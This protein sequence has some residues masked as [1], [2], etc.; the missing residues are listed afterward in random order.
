[1]S[2]R[3]VLSNE[4]ID[5]IS[6]QFVSY[7]ADNKVPQR[8]AMEL[9]L[10]LEEVLLEFQGEFGKDANV[11]VE[12]RTLFGKRVLKVQLMGHEFDPFVSQAD[13]EKAI[14]HHIYD[15]MDRAPHYSYSGGVN[16]VQFTLPSK[17]DN[18]MAKVILALVLGVGF[19]VMFNF[20][21]PEA[22]QVMVDYLVDP[23]CQVFIGMLSA[24][25]GPMIF[26]F[27]MLGI[28]NI[29]DIN[30]FS[31][32]GKPMLGRIVLY[33]ASIAAL[34][35][36]ALAPFID[37]T[38]DTSEEAEVMDVIN[39]VIAMIPTNFFTPF[40]HG[41]ILQI[42]IIAVILGICFI[43][44][45][46][47]AKTIVR[48]FDGLNK[49]IA[50]IV[51]QMNKFMPIFIFFGVAN[52]IMTG[53][54][55]QLS[56]I[57]LLV[58][59]MVVTYLMCWVVLAM[60]AWIGAKVD[61]VSF[62]KVCKKPYMAG[63]KGE[64]DREIYAALKEL[65]V[66]QKLSDFLVPLSKVLYKP[67]FAAELIAFAAYLTVACGYRLTPVWLI[68]GATMCVVISIAIPPIPGGDLVCYVIFLTQLT[69]PPEMI[70]LPAIL[71][72]LTA[73]IEAG[74]SAI[75]HISM[76]TVVA[77]RTNMMVKD[78]EGEKNEH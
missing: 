18:H 78:Q 48:F 36:I 72:S 55:Q 67:A 3:Y 8:E 64:G 43:V 66:S 17:E 40:S 34:S 74:Q 7:M 69:L 75:A 35:G 32:V 30:T 52:L 19:G 61:P 2:T 60:A 46:E 73:Y 6:G 28:Y 42:I 27:V 25:A 14:L 49:A 33:T 44:L 22:N 12:Q 50:I 29:G 41:D 39:S 26:I 63:A 38:W 62:I 1:M 37:F 15:Q 16:K 4:N 68:V 31:K 11:V 59:F 71:T 70:I 51:E 20:L 23:V 53:K 58:I 13:S 45:G 56:N 77:R 24:L 76:A 9:R 47:N 57:H 5:I 65:K 54:Y 10:S 21:F